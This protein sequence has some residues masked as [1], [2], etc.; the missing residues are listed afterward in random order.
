MLKEADK[1]VYDNKTKHELVAFWNA[2]NPKKDT[3][4]IPE[5]KG[6]SVVVRC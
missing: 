4:G 2:A 5:D 3:H 1:N 6:F